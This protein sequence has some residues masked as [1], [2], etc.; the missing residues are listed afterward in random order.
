MK[1]SSRL[2]YHY[3]IRYVTKE[4]IRLRNNRM[5]E[6]IAKNHDRS[7]WEEVRKMSKTTT[8]LPNMMDNKTDKDEIS[9][10]FSEKYNTLYNS[11]GYKSRDMNILQKDIESRI[12]NGCPNNA[13]QSN[14]KHT[15][16]VKEVKDAV[17][18][19][20]YGKK[21][22]NG[23]YSNHIK[24]GSERL[25][26]ILTLLFNCMLS[27]GIAPDELLLGTMIP[28]IKDSKGKK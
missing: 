24:H 18:K 17:D 9:I 21:E 13:E 28:L 5:G 11:V 12:E 2:K 25:F 16:T 14:H 26:V 8:S 7:L 15:I 10:I 4:N 27:H 1:R 19:L 23:L 3:A 22:E 20:K 6:A